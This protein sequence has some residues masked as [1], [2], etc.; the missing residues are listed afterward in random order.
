MNETF[1]VQPLTR[2][3]LDEILRDYVCSACWG[4][5]RFKYV[6]GKWFAFCAQCQYDT[7][8]YVSKKFAERKLE[9]SVHELA[10]AEHNLR[11][12]LGLRPK[13]QSVEKNVSDL[14]F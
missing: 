6:D 7:A 4:A 3:E 11:D 13:R 5:L 14:G 1:Q 9:E 2:D 8:G 12:V 10:E